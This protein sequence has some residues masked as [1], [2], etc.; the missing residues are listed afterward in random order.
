VSQM[1]KKCLYGRPCLGARLERGWIAWAQVPAT[2]AV[3][4]ARHV[5]TKPAKYMDGI[6]L[7]TP[8][9]GHASFTCTTHMSL[10]TTSIPGRRAEGEPDVDGV[11]GPGVDTA[12]RQDPDQ[13]QA[14]GICVGLAPRPPAGRM[15]ISKTQRR[16]PCCY[17]FRRC[18]CESPSPN[19]VQQ[20]H[21]D[22]RELPITVAGIH[23]SAAT[24]RGPTRGRNFPLRPSVLARCSAAAL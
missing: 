7:V 20:K 19:A 14:G 12:V 17:A 18:A 24:S 4:C 10:Y 1:L 9:H 6:E 2:D 3:M 22:L 11:V 5:C 8:A 23:K 21:P 13:R 16:Q 15:E